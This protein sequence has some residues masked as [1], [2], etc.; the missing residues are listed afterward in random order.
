[1]WSLQFFYMS[2]PD[3]ASG[4]K[5]AQDERDYHS[6]ISTKQPAMAATV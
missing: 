6:R 5:G 4:H 1:M 2:G 3:A